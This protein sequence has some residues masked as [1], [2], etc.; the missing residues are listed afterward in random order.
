MRDVTAGD[1]LAKLISVSPTK[2]N[3]LPYGGTC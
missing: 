3:T 2:A 1:L